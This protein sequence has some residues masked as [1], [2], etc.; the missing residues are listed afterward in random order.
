MRQAAMACAKGVGRYLSTDRTVL[1]PSESSFGAQVLDSRVPT[2]VD[3]WA[4]RCPV[5]AMLKP[6]LERLAPELVGR[7]NA[8][9]LNVDVHPAIAQA[10]GVG[11]VPALFVVK[12]RAI[13]DGLVGY[14]SLATVVARLDPFLAE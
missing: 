14:S 10:F 13:V 8:A 3:F 11:S 9:F 2:L 1:N 12:N 5:R 4:E 7:T 6:E